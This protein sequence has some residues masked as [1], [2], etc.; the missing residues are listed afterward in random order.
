MG[1]PG[2]GDMEGV[3]VIGGQMSYSFLADGK[4]VQYST[5]RINNI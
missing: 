1:K 4:N 2:M 5:V 3:D